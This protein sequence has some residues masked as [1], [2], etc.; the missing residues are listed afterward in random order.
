MS[1]LVFIDVVNISS[2]I[3]VSNR[4]VRIGNGGFGANYAGPGAVYAFFISFSVFPTS[5]SGR[6]YIWTYLVE[7][8]GNL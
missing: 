4:V 7:L 8:Y 6:W 3:A 5:L 2:D 1:S